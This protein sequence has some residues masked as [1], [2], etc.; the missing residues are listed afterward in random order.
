V[1]ETVAQQI[2]VVDPEGLIQ[3]TNPAAITAPGMKARMSSW[4]ATA[5][6]NPVFP[7]SNKACKSGPFLCSREVPRGRTGTIFG[8]GWGALRG[9]SI[10]A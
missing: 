4:G 2:W 3:F 6:S 5:G 1:L 10:C 8:T 7:T 9:A